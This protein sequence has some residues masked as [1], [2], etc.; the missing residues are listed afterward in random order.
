MLKK[1]FLTLFA[2]SV[3]VCRRGASLLRP[4][5]WRLQPGHNTAAC[6]D[7]AQQGTSGANPVLKIFNAVVQILVIVIG[8]MAII[9][10]VVLRL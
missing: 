3:G 4:M 10:L 5:F 8:A 9:M 6:K 2:S 7:V 1:L